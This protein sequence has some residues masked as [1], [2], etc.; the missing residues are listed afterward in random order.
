MYTLYKYAPINT[1]KIEEFGDLETAQ[2]AAK[3]MEESKC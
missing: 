2:L 1:L 3:K